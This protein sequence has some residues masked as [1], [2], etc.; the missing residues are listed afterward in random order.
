MVVT[1]AVAGVTEGRLR[2]YQ[3][4]TAR[5]VTLHHRLLLV[6]RSS[7]S[8][9]VPTELAEG[10]HVP[11]GRAQGCHFRV[12][13][14][15]PLDELPQRQQQAVPALGVAFEPRPAE[16]YGGIKTTNN[17][18]TALFIEFLCIC[19]TTIFG[20]SLWMGRVWNW[21]KILPFATDI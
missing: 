21:N 10:S 2:R 7:E 6:Q 16:K 8:H 3:L 20:W 5:Q 18:C 1:F 14:D 15:N 19:A 11:R 17:Q 4:T 12:L 9:E 13:A